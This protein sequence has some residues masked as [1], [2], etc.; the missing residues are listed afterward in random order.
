[1]HDFLI[2]LL[3]TPVNELR[4]S[5]KTTT[6]SR[7]DY[8]SKP[9]NRS[10]Y[11]NR[12]T[13]LIENN[14]TSDSCLLSQASTFCNS[15]QFDLSTNKDK[16]NCSKSSEHTL[17]I[18]SRH[19][20]F[21]FLPSTSVGKSPLRDMNSNSIVNRS[22]PAKRVLEQTDRDHENNNLPHKKQCFTK[23][24]KR[25]L[26]IPSTSKPTSAI[27]RRVNVT[28]HNECSSDS[29]EN[30]F[31]LPSNERVDSGFINSFEDHLDDYF[32]IE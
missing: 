12:S 3:E 26:N 4:D 1:M 20:S 25:S 19:S 32:D 22:T 30:V 14:K 18:D 5:N 17:P 31:S 28:V 27:Y 13:V 15:D 29:V 10:V 23:N 2:K 24:G 21:S 9:L 11:L 7:V 8:S 16:T 6:V